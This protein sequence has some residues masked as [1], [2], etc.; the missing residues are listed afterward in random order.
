MQRFRD[1]LQFLRSRHCSHGDRPGTRL[2]ADKSFHEQV[3]CYEYDKNPIRQNER[4]PGGRFVHAF[5]RRGAN[6]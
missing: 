1:R 4:R 2:F 5:E 3:E 6:R